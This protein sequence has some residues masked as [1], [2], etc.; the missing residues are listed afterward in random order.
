MLTGVCCA[1]PVM[2][3][4]AGGMSGMKEA[5]GSAAPELFTATGGLE[6]LRA[7]VLILLC[8]NLYKDPPSISG[9]RLPTALRPASGL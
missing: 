6:P 9:S 4:N 1:F 5:I 7:V 3:N 8:I 2:Y